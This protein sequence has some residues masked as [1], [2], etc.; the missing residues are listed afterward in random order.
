[1]RRL[2]ALFAVAPAALAAEA[3]DYSLTVYSAAQPALQRVADAHL[4]AAKRAGSCQRAV[5]G[6]DMNV[7]AARNH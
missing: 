6:F 7:L 4:A 5:I 3:P 2:L 1:M